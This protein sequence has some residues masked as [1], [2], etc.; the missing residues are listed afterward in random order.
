M[1]LESFLTSEHPPD[2]ALDFI[3]NNTVSKT[4]KVLLRSIRMPALAGT[5]D[6][7]LYGR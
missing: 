5:F 6:K 4:V 3:R 1:K 2:I 7:D